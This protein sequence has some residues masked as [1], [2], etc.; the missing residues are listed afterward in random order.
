MVNLTQKQLR[1][2]IK[3]EVES[4]TQ[5]PA[6]K[7]GA[8]AVVPDDEWRVGRSPSHKKI[9]DFDPQGKLLELLDKADEL[10]LE[11]Q[12]V[13][14]NNLELKAYV[15]KVS[16]A[17]DAVNSIARKVKDDIRGTW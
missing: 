9:D 7:R 16:S 13:V 3:E 6:T 1:S 17:E 10:M 2:I 12:E 8:K 5:A 11:A 4:M 15:K 14:E